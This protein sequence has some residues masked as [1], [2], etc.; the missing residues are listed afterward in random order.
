[1]QIQAVFIGATV[2]LSSS[3]SL[4]SDDLGLY[5]VPYGRLTVYGVYV[6]RTRMEKKRSLTGRYGHSRVPRD[7]YAASS[8]GRGRG[9]GLTEIFGG[10]KF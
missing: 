10:Q 9:E 7:Q 8:K 5:T 1:V 4:L 6:Y 2:R 3:K